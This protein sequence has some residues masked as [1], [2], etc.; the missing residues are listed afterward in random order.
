MLLLSPK[1]CPT[2]CD[3]MGCSMPGFLVLHRLLEFS[4][5]YVHWVSDNHPTISS[6]VIPFSFR[7]L[8]SSA[9]VESIHSSALSLHYDPALTSSLGYW[10]NHSFDHTDLC[11][12]SFAGPLSLLFNTVSRKAVI[13]FLPRSKCHL[14]SWLQS[15]SKMILKQKLIMDTILWQSHMLLLNIYLLPASAPVYYEG[16]I[17]KTRTTAYACVDAQSSLTLCNPIDC[18]LPGSSVHGIVQARIPEWVATSFS[19]ESSRPRDR[20]CGSCICRQ[21]LYCWAIG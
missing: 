1:S 7:R 6:S 2:L 20:T 17:Y 4:H 13:A 18:S 16:G 9:T 3:P 14:V 21:I 19:R 5:T 10:E 11:W 12:Q 15:L 8:F